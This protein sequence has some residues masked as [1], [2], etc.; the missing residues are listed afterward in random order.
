MHYLY[1]PYPPPVPTFYS[2]CYI[3]HLVRASAMHESLDDV[4][5]LCHVTSFFPPNPHHPPSSHPRSDHVT[6][7]APRRRTLQQDKRHGKETRGNGKGTRGTGS[8]QEGRE[9]RREAPARTQ[10]APRLPRHHRVQSHEA[11][12]TLPRCQT[13]GNI[14]TARAGRPSRVATSH[15]PPHCQPPPPP[16]SPI[17]DTHSLGL[18]PRDAGT[19]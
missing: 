10:Q 19:E 9:R 17:L 4:S 1:S 12:T 2:T 8:K 14:A 7:P 15:T 6:P 3:W 16:H 5:H 13:T 11:P 18:T